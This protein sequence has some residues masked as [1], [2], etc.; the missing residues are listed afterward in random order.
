MNQLAN[1]LDEALAGRVPARY[2]IPLFWQHGE[3]H[4]LLATEIDAMHRAGIA[5]FVLESRPFPGFLSEA[6]FDTVEFTLRKAEKFGMKVYVFDDSHF[7]S[8][9]ADGLIER[10]FPQ[11]LRQLLRMNYLDAIGPRPGVSLA[12]NAWQQ[13][14][15]DRLFKVVAVKMTDNV[16]GLQAGSAVDLSDR[17]APN[18]VLYWDLPPGRWRVCLFF[19]T[20]EGGEEHTRNYLNLLDP[21]AVRCYLDLVY[22][23]HYR[24]FKAD[25]GRTF[26]GFFSDE[27]RF[28]S[29]S[30]YEATLGRMPMVIPFDETLPEELAAAA[31]EDFTLSW[32][33]LWF[34]DGEAAARARTIYMDRVSRL[35]SENFTGQIG[36]WCRAHG[37]DYLGH[38]IE[39]NGAHARLGYGNGHFFRAIDGQSWSGIDRV[40]LQNVPGF[41]DGRFSSMFC[42][43][44][45]ARFFHWGLGKLGSSCGHLNP[46]MRGI[47]FCEIFG[48]YG[49]NEGLRYMK[50]MTDHFI[51]RGVNRLM[52]HAFSPREFPDPDCP[53]HFFAGGH[54]PQ[55]RAFPIWSAYANRLCHLL[56]DGV[57][58]AT[59]AVLY[60]AEAEW[61][62]GDF[63]PFETAVR[64]LALGQI[65]CDVVPLDMLAEASVSDGRLQVAEETFEV[66]VIP[67]GQRW[68]ETA[69]A[70]LQRLADA[71]LPLVW[72]REKT[73]PLPGESVAANKLVDHL[74]SCGQYDLTVTPAAPDLRFYHYQFADGDVYFLVNENLRDGLQVRL[75][76]RDAKL[77]FG[78]D[79]LRNCWSP[80]PSKK[81]F[82]LELAPGESRF[83]IRGVA[84]P[85][86]S[87]WTRFRPNTVIQLETKWKI[88]TATAEAY[89][90][91]TPFQEQASLGNLALP[92]LL[93]DFSGTIRY[94]A[95]V[96]VP[97]C[98]GRMELD[99][100]EVWEVAEVAVDGVSCGTCIVPPYRFDVTGL[101]G[102][103]RHEIQ[104][105]VTNTLAKKY[106]NNVYDRG[107]LQDPS[108][109]LGPVTIRIE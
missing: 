92:G 73:L 46:T 28:G 101:L 77:Q 109:L 70:V 81:E 104:I 3:S 53:P 5:G 21:A 69:K 99:L 36:A 27:P 74:R 57:H 51:V 45:D 24:R 96:S 95:V 18:G 71:G 82:P 12:V 61:T 43:S 34:G 97:P 44:H 48:A 66:L 98:A 26:M 42:V 49:W 93:P 7:P 102:S 94:N 23:P 107:L 56:S 31:G 89:P 59:A 62:G 39:D 17:V 25:F 20:R 14:S 30:S 8:G 1:K 33:W 4:D 86:E 55:W 105:D 16:D 35:Y 40:L 15:E 65:D 90:Q 52:P 103:G 32:P 54:N 6:W 19:R 67:Y 64:A 88:L 29:A 75:S 63:E 91:F 85:T 11:Y 80:E 22:E 79:P 87:A 106:G 13:T 10:D 68:P 83:V 78:Y 50:W 37:V 2:L 76:F 108:G 84:P 41:T 9:Y 47:T 72:L 58:R 100:G 38:V 60:H